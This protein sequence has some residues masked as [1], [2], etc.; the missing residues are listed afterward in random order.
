MKHSIMCLSQYPSSPKSSSY[1][2]EVGVNEI[3]YALSLVLALLPSTI[4]GK[5]GKQLS[6]AWKFDSNVR[7]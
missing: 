1:R 2:M 4:L 5:L 6:T 3:G 7:A